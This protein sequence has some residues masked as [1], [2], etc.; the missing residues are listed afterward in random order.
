MAMTLC[1]AARSTNQ[2]SRPVRAFSTSPTAAT[3]AAFALRIAAS[4]A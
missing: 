1:S 4:I 2:P 3:P